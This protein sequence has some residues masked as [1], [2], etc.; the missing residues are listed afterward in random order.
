MGRILEKMGIHFARSFGR[1]VGEGSSTFFWL[2]KWVGNF[3]LCEMFP[4]L[5]HLESQK[6]VLVGDRGAWE[7]AIW[8]WVL[9][10]SRELRG[11]TLNEFEDL[12]GKLQEWAPNHGHRDKRWWF[13]DESG[14]FTV[15]A[16]KELVN[17]K[18]LEGH[19]NLRETMWN[20]IVPRKVNVLVWRLRQGRMPVRVVLDHMGIDLDSLLCP[21]CQD[22]IE[23]VDH[24]F[25]RCKWVEASWNKIFNW[26]LVGHFN[27]DF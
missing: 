2:D 6:K 8:R 17:E 18:E 10:W 5:F 21:C 27:G 12:L 26:W 15:K 11:R 14:D 22:V 9:G 7:G 23:T 24:C 4:R 19:S 20:K 1:K 16:L 3:R 13:L 25:C